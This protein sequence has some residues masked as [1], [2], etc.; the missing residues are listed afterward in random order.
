MDIKTSPSNYEQISKNPLATSKILESVDFLL[1]NPISYEF[2]TTVTKELHSKKEILEIGK[3]INGCKT[4]ALQNY[5]DSPN[6]LT[7]FHPHTKETL[8]SFAHSLKPFVEHI[9]IR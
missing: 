6:V 9:V 7:H 3:W 1:T 4:Y 5:K 2:R 8:E